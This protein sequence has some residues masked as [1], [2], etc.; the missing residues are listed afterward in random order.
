ML[1]LQTVVIKLPTLKHLLIIFLALDLFWMSQISIQ[2]MDISDL[3]K[4]LM[5]WGLDMRIIL[6]NT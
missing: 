2:I 5:T 1:A 3:G 4:T 6:L